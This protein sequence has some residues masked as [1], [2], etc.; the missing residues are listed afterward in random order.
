MPSCFQLT[1]IGSH[2]PSFLQTIDAAICQNLDL[3]FSDDKWV[4][5]WYD[6]IGFA[7]ACGEDWDWILETYTGHT[8]RRI[9]HFLRENYTSDSWI[10]TR[11]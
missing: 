10:E 2:E 6:T 8:T 5:S 1:R 3:P 7:L 4:N 9:V 11:F